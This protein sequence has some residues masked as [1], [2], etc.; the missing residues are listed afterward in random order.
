MISLPRIV[1]LC[2]VLS[3][4]SVGKKLIDLLCF[5]SLLFLFPTVEIDAF[6]K[7]PC[8]TA[9]RQQQQPMAWIFYFI[10]FFL[11]DH[12]LPTETEGRMRRGKTKNKKKQQPSS[13]LPSP[14]AMELKLHPFMNIL[15][16]D[17]AKPD[18]RRQLPPLH[19]TFVKRLRFGRAQNCDVLKS[20]RRNN[21]A[22]EHVNNITSY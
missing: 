4:T 13:P 5:F 22:W 18:W 6:C 7:A 2:F 20:G 15:A 10:L 3:T 21:K 1:M 17:S 9:A 12:Q 11:T 16:F 14:P 19:W 8:W